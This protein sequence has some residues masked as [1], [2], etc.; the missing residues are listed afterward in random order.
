MKIISRKITSLYTESRKQHNFNETNFGIIKG[1]KIF[2]KHIFTE[3][4][5]YSSKNTKTCFQM[6]KFK[7]CLAPNITSTYFIF[8]S[9]SEQCSNLSSGIGSLRHS[10]ILQYYII[11]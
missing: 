2:Q 9:P 7:K 5:K 3:T 8:G 1:F 11:K 10:I 6:K 4:N